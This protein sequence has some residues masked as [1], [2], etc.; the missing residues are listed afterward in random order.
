MKFI[1]L[2]LIIFISIATSYAQNSSTSGYIVVEITIGKH[3][4]LSKVE[5]TTCKP[6]R[7]SGWIRN[8]E[9]GVAEGIKAGKRPKKGKYIASVR[10]IV[11]K[12]GYPSD[13]K[14]EN[15][16]GYGFCEQVMRFVK[17]SPKWRPVQQGF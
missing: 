16:P 17:K 8:L 1:L 10:Y 2:S 6:A 12:E 15:N 4:I 14:C 5:V 7:D 13:V 3:H 11:S 9:N